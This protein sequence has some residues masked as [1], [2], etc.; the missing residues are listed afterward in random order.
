M[1]INIFMIILL[2][3]HKCKPRFFPNPYI[4]TMFVEYSKTLLFRIVILVVSI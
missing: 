3:F 2:L 1:K 4:H